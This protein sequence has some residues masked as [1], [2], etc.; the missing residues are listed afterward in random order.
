LT[1]GSADPS[2]QSRTSRRPARHDRPARDSVRAWVVVAAAFAAL[3]SLFGVAF[4]FGAFFGPIAAEFETGRAAASA[5]FSLTSL[6]F[7]SLG[8][9]SGPAADRLGSRPLLLAGAAAFGSGLAATA[10]AD[11]LWIA[12][13]TYGVGVG[14]GVGCTYVPIIAAVGGWFEHRRA[15]AVGVA[16]SGIRLDTLAAA[17]LGAR[18]ID[19]YGWRT[20]YLGFAVASSA[21]LILSTLLISAP[22][23]APT[24]TRRR[25]GA[26]LR[27][28]TYGWLY[29]S[30]LLL[31]LVL[32][33]PF[34][35]LPAFAEEAGVGATAAAGLVGIVGAASIAGRVVLGV[36]ADAAGL[37]RGYRL[38][39]LLIGASFALWWVGDGFWSLAAFAA[40]LGVGYGG[41]V[42]L[43]PV[44]LAALF[45]VEQLGGLLG[46]LLTAN[47]LGSAIGPPAVG[48]V[49]DLTGTYASAI[50]ALTLL[51]FAA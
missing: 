14:V 21:V 4:S 28:P 30:N 46:V 29:L 43:S 47:G 39:F 40:V 38:S 9:A 50:A 44:V 3:F 24:G 37:L 6:L 8:A 49:G 16:V 31:C 25:T 41:F 22:P 27:T 42:A 19:A 15:L 26:A 33:V 45:G 23:G 20:V 35:H 1:D 32:F 34:V 36:V 11:R 18:L 51:G 13:L 12:Y 5:V 7:F 48:L 10:A 2:R 17:P